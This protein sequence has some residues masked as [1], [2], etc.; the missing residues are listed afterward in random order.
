MNEMETALE[1]I[2]TSMAAALPTRTVQRSLVLDPMNHDP[3]ALARGVVCLVAG[4]GGRFAN[5]LGREGQLGHLQLGVVAFV[6]APEG[7]APAAVEQAEL[8]LLAEVL[9]WVR[10]PGLPKP[11]DSALP[12]DWRQSRQ[13]E[14]PYGWFSL[15]IDVRP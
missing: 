9:G 14:A 10:A 6:K 15:E 12:G 4:G 3:A 7:S 5:Y 11:W 13:Q 8:A 1:A 2:K